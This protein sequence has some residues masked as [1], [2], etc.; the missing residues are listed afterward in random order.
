LGTTLPF[1]TTIVAINYVTITPNTI[2][3]GREKEGV[4]GSKRVG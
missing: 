3:K 1:T 2:K 4:W